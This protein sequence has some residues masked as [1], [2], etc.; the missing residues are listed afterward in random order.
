MYIK[1]SD[2]LFNLDCF[3][4]KIC[5]KLADYHNNLHPKSIFEYEKILQGEYN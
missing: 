3:L 1:K 4:L 5:L 2:I